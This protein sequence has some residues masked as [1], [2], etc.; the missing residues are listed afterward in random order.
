MSRTSDTFDSLQTR[1]SKAVQMEQKRIM[2]KPMRLQ[3]A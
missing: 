1:V 3:T 2:T